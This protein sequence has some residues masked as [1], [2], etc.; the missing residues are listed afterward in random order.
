[1]LKL[2][3]ERSGVRDMN[4][5]QPELKH[6]WP[7]VRDKLVLALLPTVAV[8][9]TIALLEAFGRQHLMCSSLAS[10]AF[11]I[12]ADPGHEM[13][14]IRALVVSQMTAAGVGWLMW[15]LFGGGFA[16]AAG[17]IPL[18]ILLMILLKAVY[19]PAAIHPPA[20]STALAF[21]MHTDPTS[22]FIL[23]AIAVGITGLLVVLQQVVSGLIRSNP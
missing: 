8:V 18:S 7:K 5:A 21:A 9:P 16:A 3:N 23:F 19:P 10:S 14:G 12:Y 15:L 22:S 1:M 11:L 13:N 20:L 2:P 6:R 4:P 17:A